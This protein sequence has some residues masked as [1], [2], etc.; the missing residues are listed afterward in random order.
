MVAGSIGFE[1][2]GFGTRVWGWM[3]GEEDEHGLG[4]KRILMVVIDQG[5]CSVDP[6]FIMFQDLFQMKNQGLKKN[7]M[8]SIADKLEVPPQEN[9]LE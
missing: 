4:V 3:I 7:E 6:V 8:L 9:V 1:S 5:M 2:G